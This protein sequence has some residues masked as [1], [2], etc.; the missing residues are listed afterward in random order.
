MK[1]SNAKPEALKPVGEKGRFV[2]L[3]AV[4]RE[5]YQVH[6]I[7]TV[8]Q[9]VVRREVLSA[10]RGDVVDGKRIQG[11]TLAAAYSALTAAMGKHL[12]EA[13]DLWKP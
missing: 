7:E 12:R 11:D 5:R 10:G 1:N 4:G 3:V 13:S 9:T 6:L 2:G 8:G